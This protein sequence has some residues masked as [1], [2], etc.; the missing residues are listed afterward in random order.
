[1]GTNLKHEEQEFQD[2]FVA[3]NSLFN[4]L[5]GQLD[6]HIKK[7]KKEVGPLPHTIY[8]INSKQTTGLNVRTESIKLLEESIGVNLYDLGLG[9]GFLDMTTKVQAI[10]E[11]VDKLDFIK[12]K[13]SCI[14]DTIKK[15]KRQPT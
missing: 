6:F 7:K 5:L 4:M 3:K 11:K 10:K 9:N 2:N 15:V 14:K 12:I 1:M 8:K 13:K